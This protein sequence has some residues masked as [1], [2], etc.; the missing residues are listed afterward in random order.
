MNRNILMNE[1][2][3]SCHAITIVDNELIGD[4]LEIKMFQSTN[5]EL[6]ETIQKDGSED[7]LCHVRP[8]NN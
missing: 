3:A 4:P 7:V 1:A 8:K 6:D 2:M 5:W